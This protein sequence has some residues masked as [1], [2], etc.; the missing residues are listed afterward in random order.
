MLRNAREVKMETVEY[1]GRPDCVRLS[2]GAVELIAATDIGPRIL[3]YG[4]VD[5]DNLLGAA[6]EAGLTT[7]LG[8]WKAWG[9]H[10]L[11]AAPEN[12]P[13]SYVPDNDPIEW[14][15]L[16]ERSVRLVRPVEGPTGIAKEI[17]VSLDAEG[18]GATVAHRITNRNLWPIELAPWAITILNGEGGGTVVIPQ[19][20]YR[21]HDEALLPARPMVLWH[22]TDLTDPRWAIG[23]KL[24]RLRVD[25]AREEPQ[26]LGVADKQ[27]WAAYLCGSTAFVKDFGYE[28]GLPYPDE[29]CNCETY[30]AGAFVELESLAPMHYLAPG[31]FAEHTETWRIVQNVELGNGEDDVILRALRGDIAD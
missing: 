21:S 25:A 16:G 7:G 26:K 13:R 8:E 19:E 1:L 28:P 2:N 15:G 23:R 5:G 10:R 17:V 11:W 27:G 30:T 9:G 31:E 3:R 20:P 29:G 6:P 14:T 22:Y 18:T 4:L 12:D 24:V